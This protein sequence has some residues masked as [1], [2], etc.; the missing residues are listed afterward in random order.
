MQYTTFFDL[1]VKRSRMVVELLGPQTWSTL[2]IVYRQVRQQGCRHAKVPGSSVW[3]PSEVC[4][5]TSRRLRS[6]RCA[7]TGGSGKIVAVAGSVVRMFVKQNV[8]EARTQTNN[9][10]T[11]DRLM[12]KHFAVKRLNYV[13]F[14]Q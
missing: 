1:Q 13:N 8:L 6:R 4:T 5:R 12:L 14:T 10:Q 9:K 2:D 7:T 3:D 11:K